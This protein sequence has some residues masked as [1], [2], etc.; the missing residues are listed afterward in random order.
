MQVSSVQAFFGLPGRTAYSAAKH[1]ALGFYDSLRAEVA[2][3]GIAVTT[4]CPGYMATEHGRNAAG[5]VQEHGAKGVPPQVLAPKV[6][7]GIARRKAE[8]VRF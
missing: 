4:V 8:L 1:A 5:Q 2:S 3:N 6:L 7:A